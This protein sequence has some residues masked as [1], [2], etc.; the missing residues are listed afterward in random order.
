VHG[1]VCERDGGAGCG[2][3][4]ELGVDASVC[5]R[6]VAVVVVGGGWGGY[7]VREGDVW[8]VC[9]GAQGVAAVLLL[10]QRRRGMA[11]EEREVD[12]RL[13]D[14]A[15]RG[16]V[17]G[18]SLAL[19]A[20]ANVTLNEGTEWYTPLQWAAMYGHVAAMEAL[21]AAGA[22]VDGVDSSGLTPLMY[23]AVY[24]R[25]AAVAVLLAAGADVHR[26]S[27]DGHTALHLACRAGTFRCAHALLEAGAR[28]DV[29][30]RDGERPI[31]VVRAVLPALQSW[32]CN[33]CAWCAGMP[34][35][36][37]VRC[38]SPHRTADRCGAVGPP[39]RRRDGVLRWCVAV[40][41]G[42]GVSGLGGAYFGLR[43]R[44]R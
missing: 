36:K 14:A 1:G 2:G 5:C 12:Q 32:S 37:Q 42:G 10:E 27:S 24:A 38:P 29:R 40:V 39:P 25:A 30:N 15:K 28:A 9:R 33:V 11:A 44:V 16:D 35:C 41:G 43:G 13:C 19:L 8:C 21:L 22:H 3:V 26:V 31:D 20:G 6:G 17:A 7:C 18:I 34:N 23:A 4:V